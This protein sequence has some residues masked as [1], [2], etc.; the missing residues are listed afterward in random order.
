MYEV[1]GFSLSNDQLKIEQYLETTKRPTAYK[2]ASQF[3][4]WGLRPVIIE[5]RKN[6]RK[7]RDLP[8]PPKGAKE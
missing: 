6:W 4:S 8:Y 1:Y 7:G 3:Q 5:W 2:L